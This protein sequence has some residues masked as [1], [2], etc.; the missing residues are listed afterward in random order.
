MGIMSTTSSLMLSCIMNT[1][2]A[3]H[4]GLCTNPPAS[5]QLESIH[6]Q[7]NMMYGIPLGEHIKPMCRECFLEPG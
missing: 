6:T 2:V 1:Y 5:Q 7:T 4:I 3:N